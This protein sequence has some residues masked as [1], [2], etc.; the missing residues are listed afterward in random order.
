VPNAHTQLSPIREML[1]NIIKLKKKGNICCGGVVK[2]LLFI[3]LPKNSRVALFRG[4]SAITRRPKGFLSRTTKGWL[5]LSS[6]Y[7]VF[8]V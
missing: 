4:N 1:K 6:Q 8:L 3:K 5:F 2:A 7:I